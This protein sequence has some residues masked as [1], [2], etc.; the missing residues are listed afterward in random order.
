M[1]KANTNKEKEEYRKTGRCFECGK[2]GHLACLCP[3]KKNRPSP[4]QNPSDN[5]IVE[6]EDDDESV[7]DSQAYH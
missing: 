3:S 7:V 2:Q 6:V 1:R 5:R 4:F